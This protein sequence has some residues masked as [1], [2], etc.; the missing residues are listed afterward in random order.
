MSRFRKIKKK[1]EKQLPPK[2]EPEEAQDEGL[3]EGK[4]KIGTIKIDVYNDM[5][6]AVFNFPTNPQVA[7]MVLC[8][9]LMKVFNWFMEEQAK[10][11]SQIVIAKP[12][13]SMADIEKMSRNN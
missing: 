9:A 13:A 12:G 7:M 8:N 4:K 1:K 11:K 6:V 3:P 10:N 2:P 5:D